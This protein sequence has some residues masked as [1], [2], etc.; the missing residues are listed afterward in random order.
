MGAGAGVIAVTVEVS[1]YVT[2]I[3]GYILGKVR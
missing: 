1:L 2:D 3:V